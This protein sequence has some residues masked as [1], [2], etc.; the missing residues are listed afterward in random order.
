[1]SASGTLSGALLAVSDTPEEPTVSNLYRSPL[2]YPVSFERECNPNLLI[3]SDIC[4]PT[5]PLISRCSQT[6]HNKPGHHL[7]IR[8]LPQPIVEHPHLLHRH[9]DSLCLWQAPLT[10]DRATAEYHHCVISSPQH[11]LSVFGTLLGSG[12]FVRSPQAATMR[13]PQS[14]AQLGFPFSHHRPSLA[15]NKIALTV[16]NPKQTSPKQQDLRIDRAGCQERL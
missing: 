11:Q 5:P 13:R 8:L 12:R 9:H 3:D 7:P 4:F 2:S 16:R 14:L 1:M 10:P 6:T 15:M